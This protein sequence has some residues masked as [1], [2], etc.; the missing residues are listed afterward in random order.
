[1]KVES[2]LTERLLP[3]STWKYKIRLDIFNVHEK[4]KF[5]PWDLTYI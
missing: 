3:K 1:M 5:D 2:Y 4:A